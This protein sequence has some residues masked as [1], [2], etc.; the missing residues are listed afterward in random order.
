MMTTEQHQDLARI[1]KNALDVQSACNL[2]GV[3]F[4]FAKDMRTLCD[5]QHSGANV[6]E[7]GTVNRNRHPICI[8]YATQISHLVGASFDH[9]GYIK[10]HDWAKSQSN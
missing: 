1:A 3:V 2:S 6:I 8:L 10:A 9:A 7:P 4:S 5:L